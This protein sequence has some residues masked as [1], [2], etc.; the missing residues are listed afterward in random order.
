MTRALELEDVRAG[1][2][3]IEILHGV[4]LAGAR[5]FGRRAA[6]AERRRQDHDAARH[7]RH[8]AGDVGRRSGSTGGASTT[9]APAPSRRGARARARGSRRVPGAHRPRQPAGRPP[10]RAEGGRRPVGQWL[11]EIDHDVPAARRAPRPG[12]RL[13]VGWR[14]ADAGR[15]PALWSATPASSCS[16]SCRWAWRRSSWPTC[17]TAS[18]PCAT[19]G[20]TIVLVEQ[21]LTY[22][23]ELADL[24][25]VLAKGQV[26][27][28]GE[29]A[30][31]RH[32]PTAAAY[33][34]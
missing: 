25:Y 8:A 10:Q 22:A 23:L 34:T 15:V 1:Y 26:V 13:A 6:R 9:A 7:L 21:Y 11:D 33:L 19:P 29:P 5:G 17:S 16:T 30:E 28:A 24:C 27:W 3:R 32:L 4:N 18:P 31:L 12:G 14:A 2:G 20:R